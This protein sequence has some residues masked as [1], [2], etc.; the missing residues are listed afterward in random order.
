[1]ERLLLDLDTYGGTDPLCM[2]PL[3]L[4]R[5]DD[6]LAPRLSVVFRQILRLGSFPGETTQTMETGQCHPN[7]K[8]SIVIL[9]CQ[10]P[11]NFHNTSTVKGV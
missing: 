4:K 8:R 3:L 2:F 1:M 10:L 7:S 6:V 11:T 5:M 9:C